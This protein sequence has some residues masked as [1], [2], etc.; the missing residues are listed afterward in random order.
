M[1]LV[2]SSSS[3]RVAE[4]KKL[5]MSILEALPAD[6]DDAKNESKGGKQTAKTGSSD[7]MNIFDHKTVPPTEEEGEEEVFFDGLQQ[8]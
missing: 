7:E 8:E 4:T 1:F 5:A 3:L 2:A 6:P